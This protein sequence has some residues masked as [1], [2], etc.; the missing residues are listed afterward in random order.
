[1]MDKTYHV[2]AHANPYHNEEYLAPMR[3][4]RKCAK[5]MLDQVNF[6]CFNDIVSALPM[7]Y[8][9][10]CSM[11]VSG[12]VLCMYVYTTFLQFSVVL[13]TFSFIVIT[14]MS[15]HMVCKVLYHILPASTLTLKD[16]MTHLAHHTI[17]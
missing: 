15:Y 1:M 5:A 6:E 16:I 11:L 8:L 2:C 14:C 4:A 10:S 9:L 7:L 12:S 3:A 17:S 13:L